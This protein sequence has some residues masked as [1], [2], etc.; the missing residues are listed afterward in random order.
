MRHIGTSAFGI[1]LPIINP[2]DNLA[3]ITADSLLKACTSEGIDLKETDILGVTEAVVAKAQSNYATLDDIAADVRNKFGGGNIGL[4]FPI[5]SRNRF[6]SLLKGVSRGAEK[7][8]VLLNFPADEQGNPLIELDKIDDFYDKIGNK[9]FLMTGK[10]FRETAGEFLHPFT[11][12]DYISLY[13]QAGENIE[14]YVSD[15]P[16]TIL[17]LTKNVIACDV[18][19]RFITKKRLIKGGAKKAYALSDIL[20]TEAQKGSG[21]NPEYGVLGSNLATDDRLKLFPRDCQQF[22]SQLRTAIFDRTGKNIEVLVY[23][24]GAFKDPEYGIWELADPVVSPAYTGNLDNRPTE[25]K[26][27]YIADSKFAHLDGEEKNKAVT[28]FIKNKDLWEENLME[29]TTP[30]KYA[31][32]LGSLCDLL[33]GSGSKGTPVVLIKGYFDDYTTE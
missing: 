22:V 15:D 29:G 27:K 13:E 23:G 19:G 20:N 32:L 26:L 4:V 25:V 10:E 30:R 31:D 14:V 5:L 21:Y 16:R 18:H 28:D 11:N 24:D 3:E 8:T 2:G 33:S 17:K 1:R 12:I 9:S 6:L 7:V